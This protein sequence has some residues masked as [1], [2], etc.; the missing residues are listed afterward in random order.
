MKKQISGF[1]IEARETSAF[2]PGFFPAG[3]RGGVLTPPRPSSTRAFRPGFIFFSSAFLIIGTTSGCSS[4]IF[5][6][7]KPFEEKSQTYSI[8]DISKGNSSWSKLT[9]SEKKAGH[10]QSH[11][12]LNADISDVAFFSK[13][14]GATISLNSTC[15][16]YS[17]SAKKPSLRKLTNEL[18]SGTLNPQSSASPMFK[19]EKDLVIQN[20]AALQTITKGVLNGHDFVIKAVV[21]QSGNC[22]YDMIYVAKAEKFKQNENDFSR[23]ISSLRL[24]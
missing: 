16:N 1:F 10:E 20:T 3:K 12:S 15:K 8:L 4:L 11:N 23:F 14:T 18:L 22:I 21:L 2:K 24:K 5:G 19:E 13:D 7:I 17:G 9:N 6:N